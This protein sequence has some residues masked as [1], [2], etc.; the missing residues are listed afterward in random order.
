MFVT[1]G[2]W[3]VIFLLIYL[4]IVS[5]I[6]INKYKQKYIVYE[7]EIKMLSTLYLSKDSLVQNLITMIDSNDLLAM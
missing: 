6:E 5:H 3:I 7:K 2:L 4:I 1:I